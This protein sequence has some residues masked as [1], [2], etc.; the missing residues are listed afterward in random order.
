M[1]G[2]SVLIS[3]LVTVLTTAPSAAADSS[4]QDLKLEAGR[5]LFFDRQLS[6]PPGTSCASCHDPARA[7]TGDNGSGSAVPRGSRPETRGTRNAPTV[8]Y[9]ATSPGPGFFEKDGTSVPRGGFFWDGRAATLADQALGPLFTP[10]E[11][12][13]RDAVALVAKVAASD[14]APM[15]RRAFGADVFTDPG[16]ALRAI[17]ASITAFE[18]SPELAPFS[19]KFDAVLRGQAR[20]TPAE[21]RGQS[22]FTI[23][24]KGN[25]AA[26]HTLNPDSRDPR[27]SLFTD[28]GFHALGVP[29]NPDVARAGEFDL[30]YCGALPG[31]A[32][33]NARWCG[34]FKTPTLR[35]IA[36]TAPYMHNGRFATLRE[37]VAFYATRDTNPERWYPAGEKFNDLP[38]TLRGNVDL[39]TRPYHRRPGQ[40][41]ALNDEEIDDIV[42]FLNTL[43]DGY[44]P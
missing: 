12:N 42:A 32:G 16:N 28:F 4:P 23:A 27:D 24:Q 10:H 1:R 41:P 18:Q 2:L 7:F 39:D 8:M 29:R 19:S 22:L 21:E 5:Q 40:R 25:C 9:L 34:W 30:G 6:E 3:A 31:G 14:A 44:A 38:P 15:L 37:A 26:C 13:N 43:T 20:F 17:T 11:M 33:A 36:V 35:N